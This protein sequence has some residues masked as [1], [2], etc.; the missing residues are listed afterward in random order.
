[1]SL[2]RKSARTVFKE[3]AKLLQL[4]WKYIQHF[5]TTKNGCQRSKNEFNLNQLVAGRRASYVAVLDFIEHNFDVSTKLSSA[6]ATNDG[7]NKLKRKIPED[8]DEESELVRCKRLKN[9]SDSRKTSSVSFERRRSSQFYIFINSNYDVNVLQESDDNREEDSASKDELGASCPSSTSTTQLSSSPELSRLVELDALNDDQAQQLIRSATIGKGSFGRVL[10]SQI[11]G[12]RL[13]IKVT[14]YE[15]QGCECDG[16][17]NGLRLMHHRNVAQTR[18]IIRLRSGDADSE[19]I[20]VFDADQSWYANELPYGHY[21][22]WTVSE[23]TKVLWSQ[24]LGSTLHSMLAADVQLV[25]MEVAGDC[26]LQQLLDDHQRHRIDKRRRFT[27][28]HQICAALEHLKRNRIAHLDLKPA[29]VMVN[30]STNLVKLIDF[31]CSREV[32]DDPMIVS[33]STNGVPSVYERNIFSFPNSLTWSSPSS[34]VSSPTF[35]TVDPLSP[36][37]FSPT[38]R[39][40]QTKSVASSF[41]KS[42]NCSSRCDSRKNDIGTIPYTAPEI[43]RC[44]VSD[45]FKADIFSLGITLWQIISRRAPYHGE[46]LHSIIYR[47]SSCFSHFVFLT[48]MPK[49]NSGFYL[50]KQVVSDRLRPTFDETFEQKEPVYCQLAARCWDS[51]PSQRPSIEQISSLIRNLQ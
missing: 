27:L 25:L 3:K 47:V 20:D 51:D 18:H 45:Y 44:D 33:P 21:N 32:Q 12:E 9:L 50:L 22:E 1:M 11:N 46:N 49:I 6:N 31:G 16:E 26:S 39:A 43:F 8:D 34:A 35:L 29:N 14:I 15:H 38:H 7:I 23:R 17:H 5:Q 28:I 40:T 19:A 37:Q 4:A 30:C 24:L 36:F 2:N 41:H 10:R 42:K 13:A 48:L